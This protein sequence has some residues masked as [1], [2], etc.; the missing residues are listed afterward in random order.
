MKDEND[1]IIKGKWSYSRTTATNNLTL[2]KEHPVFL[3]D[4][5]NTDM[6]NNFVIEMDTQLLETRMLSIKS[7]ATAIYQH[8]R[9]RQSSKIKSK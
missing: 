4:N 8:L 2:I 5:K 6:R 1:E 9:L 7:V 3:E